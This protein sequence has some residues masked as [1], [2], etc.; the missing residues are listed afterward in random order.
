MYDSATIFV[1]PEHFYSFCVNVQSLFS[2]CQTNICNSFKSQ[3]WKKVYIFISFCLI[4]NVVYLK[5]EV[6]HDSFFNLYI[7]AN[8]IYCWLR[9][10]LT[11]II[12]MPAWSLSYPDLF[13]FSKATRHVSHCWNDILPYRLHSCMN[14]QL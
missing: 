7:T 12:T 14:V 9:N 8:F 4:K 3:L 13:S 6:F 2:V 5:I 10:K 11:F 1:I